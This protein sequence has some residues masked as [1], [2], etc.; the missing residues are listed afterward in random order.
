MK[1][2]RWLEYGLLLLFFILF[3]II[4]SIH[5]N[6]FLNFVSDQ[7]SQAKDVLEMFRTHHLRL[8]G[9]PITSVVYQGRLM[10][11][12]PA[13]YYQLLFFMILGNWD[14]VVSSYLFM[15][16]CGLMIVPLFYG[17]SFLLGKKT[18]WAVVSIYTL[19]PFFVNYTRFHWNPTYQLSLVPITV[20]FMGLYEKFRQHRYYFIFFIILGILFQYHY[21]FIFTVAGIFLFY[22]Y[23]GKD[24]L[25]TFL[26][27][28]FG[29]ILG[30][31]PLIVFELRN[32]FYNTSTFI[33]YLQNWNQVSRVG[34]WQTPHYYL[35]VSLFVIIAG[36]AFIKWWLQRMSKEKNKNGK[37]I[38]YLI[39]SKKV[40]LIFIFLL[41][42]LLLVWSAFSFFRQPTEAFW[43]PTSN[44]NYL[45]EK[46]AF[47]LVKNKNVK[48]FN[49]VDLSYFDTKASV[50]KYLLEKES[51]KINEEDYRG[52]KYL[53]VTRNNARKLT[54]S[55][56]YELLELGPSK[57]IESWKL[58]N[59]FRLDLLE[60]I[61]Q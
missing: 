35:G 46:K 59:Y 3:V 57:L 47:D 27:A 8:I 12:G 38:T 54:D 56:P 44:W 9:S 40:Y 36:A 15:I 41:S 23:R 37:L 20:L 43:S 52:N 26:F 28:A 4:R 25:K 58:N 7:A 33:L 29:F 21:Q 53:F 11:L 5:F 34:N 14:P 31:S 61:P 17:V 30:I 49:I 55:P 39:K 48:D 10:F 50:V 22:M 42:F 32:K 51:I 60:R 6:Y 24:K 19:L 45:G 13:Y 1:K 18:A 2:N 16:F